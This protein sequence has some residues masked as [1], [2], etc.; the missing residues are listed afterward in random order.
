MEQHSKS[1]IKIAEFLQSHPSVEKVLYPGLPS[2]PQYKLSLKQCKGH[3]GIMS[4]YIKDG[5]EAAK[6]FL[7]SLRVIVLATSLGD[8]ESLASI[9]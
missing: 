1:A 8:V 4:F 3:T 2:H 9:P 6:K 5:L 7:Q